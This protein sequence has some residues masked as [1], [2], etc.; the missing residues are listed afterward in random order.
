MACKGA[1]RRAWREWQDG[2]VA[3]ETEAEGAAAATEFQDGDGRVA[4]FVSG[5]KSSVA[6]KTALVDEAGYRRG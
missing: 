5:E 6:D 1:K 3:G 2:Q 4:N